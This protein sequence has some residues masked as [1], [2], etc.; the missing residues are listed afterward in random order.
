MRI[1]KFLKEVLTLPLTAVTAPSRCQVL[2]EKYAEWYYSRPV[3]RY[4]MGVSLNGRRKFRG[5]AGLKINIG[6][7]DGWYNQ[8][9]IGIDYKGAYP[10]K[11]KTSRGGFDLNWDILRGLPFDDG[12]VSVIYCS[13]FL[14]HLTFNQAGRLLKECYRVL[15]NG[16]VIRIVVPDLDLFVDKMLKRDETFFKNVET[17][18]G[19]W[20]G[21]LTDTFL[22]NFY[23]SPEW[24]NTCHKYAYN[25]ENLT[26][27][28]KG[29]GFRKVVR[30]GNMKSL[31][32]ELNNP[33]FDSSNTKVPVFSLYVEAVK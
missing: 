23:S 6:C 12:S 17:A 13:H 16:G 14:E 26:F 7:G 33:V 20:L 18:G 9:W 30:S 11:R 4:M 27:R 31:C 25:V 29:A 19:E 28:L 21:N 22:M 2:V 3:S 8:G 24:N 5:K 15:E 10:Y 1:L 32:N